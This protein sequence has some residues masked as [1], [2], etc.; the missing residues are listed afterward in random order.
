MITF[1]IMT[2]VYFLFI[3]VRKLMGYEVPV[4]N[5]LEIVIIF[6]AVMVIILSLWDDIKSSLKRRFRWKR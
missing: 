5:I 3:G 6:F 1:V 4:K 2:I